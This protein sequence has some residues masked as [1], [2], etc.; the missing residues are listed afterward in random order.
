MIQLIVNPKTIINF[1][2]KYF[3]I[4]VIINKIIGVTSTT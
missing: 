4:E 3:Q 2:I 1:I